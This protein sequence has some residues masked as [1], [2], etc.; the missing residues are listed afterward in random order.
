MK[1]ASCIVVGAGSAGATVAGRLSENPALDVLV[2]EAGPDWTYDDC[3]PNIRHPTNMYSWDISTLDVVPP[4]FLWEE[5]KAIRTAGRHPAKY[6]RGKGLGGSSAVNGCYAIRPPMEEFDEW[7]AAG[8]SGWGSDDVLPYFKRLERDAEFGDAPYHGIDGPTPITRVPQEDWGTIDVGLLESASKLGH[9]WAP[10]HN[11]PRTQ[12]I[13]LTASNLENSLRVTTNDSYLEPARAR[14]NLEIV[15]NARVAKVLFSGS[16]A[17][18]VSAVVGGELREFYAD[19]IILS[20]GAVMT[21]AILQRSGVGPATLLRR[22]DIAVLADLP[23]GIGL[24]DHAGFELLLRIPD[25]RPARSGRRRG[26]CTV[27]YSSGMPESGFGDL[28]ITDVNLAKGSDLGGLLC[29]LAKCHAR[30]AVTISSTDPAATPDVNFNLLGDRRDVMLTR[31]ALRHAFDLVR[32]GGFPD[33]TAL[34]DVSGGDIDLSMGDS[35]LDAW[36]TS[37]VRDTAHAS[38]GCAIGGPDDA[39]AVLDNECRVRGV[40]GLR[41]ADASVFPTVPRANTHL[42]A[43]MVG[44]RV[45]DWVLQG[46]SKRDPISAQQA[47]SGSQ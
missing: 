21:P 47:H 9:P 12:G 3:P 39:A 8:C 28:L 26:N 27:R 38:S 32:S 34:V 24:Q 5:Q 7:A 40:D 45:A 33:K 35:E 31:Y 17:I 16:R 25:G 10:D 23:V 22:L 4:E 42:P 43:I 20:A 15:G 18:G 13:A 14:T 11:A 41:V 29:K 46:H 37:V 44:E 2:L 19:E 30:G 36:A 1:E 6:T